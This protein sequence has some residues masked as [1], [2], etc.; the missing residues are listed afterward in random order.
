MTD[1]SKA[2]IRKALAVF[3]KQVYAPGSISGGILQASRPNDSAE[4]NEEEDSKRS[5]K[6]IDSFVKELDDAA[7][8]VANR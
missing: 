8:R 1:S 5:D 4:W 7:T 3:F 6:S 2:R